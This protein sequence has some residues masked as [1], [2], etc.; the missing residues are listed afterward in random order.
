VSL[1]GLKVA[2]TGSR[3]AIELAHLIS[4]KGGIPYIAPTIGIGS[5]NSAEVETKKFIK[6]VIEGKPDYSV[7]MTGPGVYSVLQTA[8]K[9]GSKEDLIRSLVKTKV[10]ARSQKPKD[11]LSKHGVKVDMIPVSTHDN[12]A[13]GVAR[14]L[15]KNNL[16][17]KHILI[18]W[19]GSQTE[20]LGKK[21]M[22]A[23]ARVSEFRIYEYSTEL[24]AEG[25]EILNRMGYRSIPPEETRVRELIDNILTHQIN[26][27]TFT[28]PPSV[29]NLFSIAQKY[30]RESDLIEAMDSGQIV[31]AIGQPTKEAIES[32]GVKVDVMPDIFKLGPMVAALVDYVKMDQSKKE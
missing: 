5:R 27:V 4:S 22:L 14:E 20:S 3:R 6:E 28:S 21:L 7:F 23:G 25:A 9:L 18:V 30:S 11:A 16:E 31:V 19:H 12:T 10:V 29:R 24:S 26:A 17:G 13:E 8:E 15:L 1:N 2:V 32:F